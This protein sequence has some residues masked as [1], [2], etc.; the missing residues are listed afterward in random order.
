SRVPTD[1]G[2]PGARGAGRLTALTRLLPIGVAATY[3]V[4]QL[5]G[6]ASFDEDAGILATIALDHVDNGTL[7][8]TGPPIFGSWRLG[9]LAPLI[10]MAPVRLSH[11]PR[12]AYVLVTL[13]GIA[14]LPIVFAAARRVQAANLFPHVA[15]AIF[16]VWMNLF[17]TP[18]RPVNATFLPIFLA[19]AFYFLVRA[20]RGER[21]AFLLAWVFVGLCVQLH[22]TASILALTILWFASTRGV[23]TLLAQAALGFVVVAALHVT[24]IAKALSGGAPA[25]E[26]A[27]GAAAMRGDFGTMAAAL[28]EIAIEWS[29]VGVFGIG[30]V[31][32]IYLVRGFRGAIASRRHQTHTVGVPRVAATH[33][34]LASVI[35]P[36]LKVVK[37]A[38]ITDVGYLIAVAPFVAVL[39][40]QGA[41]S[42]VARVRH[43]PGAWPR[44]VLPWF[45]ASMMLV[46]VG[47]FVY[48]SASDK[49][50]LCLHWNA[51][52]LSRQMELAGHIDSLAQG[53]G[54]GAPPPKAAG[55]DVDYRIE[56]FR[57]VTGRFSDE[58]MLFSRSPYTYEVLLRWMRGVRYGRDA[59]PN[60][61][62]GVVLRPADMPMP[63]AMRHAIKAG[64]LL[65]ERRG[66][67]TTVTIFDTPREIVLSP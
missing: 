26:A 46:I 5:L 9:P 42:D 12:L 2:R 40:A 15:T 36:L 19:G 18:I 25:V 24:V 65:G 32:A 3:V 60:R 52:R 59:A 10:M 4:N 58:P 37:N 56:H 64:R 54:S 13:L 27:A 14:A 7:P 41:S 48:A 30:G 67:C 50:P 39:V 17:I 6:F 28:A 8:R 47:S 22:M 11:D 44:T 20:V 29:L 35:L 45:V 31:A 38:G 49:P 55:A 66:E 34:I 51:V 61:T 53:R 63:E 16:G 21:G 43:D 62:I 57:Y 1:A 23:R 33:L